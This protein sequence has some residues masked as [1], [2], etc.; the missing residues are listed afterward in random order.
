VAALFATPAAAT[1]N[2]SFGSGGAAEGAPLSYTSPA[3]AGIDELTVNFRLDDIVLTALSITDAAPGAFVSLRT[4]PGFTYEGSSTSWYEQLILGQIGGDGSFSIS[5][6]I[7]FGPSTQWGYAFALLRVG[8]MHG[9][10]GV[11]R[12][13][14]TLSAFA[15]EGYAAAPIP[16][17]GTWALMIVGL[18][19]MGS[20]LRRKR[21]AT[22]QPV[23]L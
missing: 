3:L 22:G 1:T 8:D 20:G 12:D 13:P 5:E 14:F 23:A 4:T 6:P 2:I 17:P 10:G 16:E 21:P 15:F 11:E 7:E 18:G 9:P 19:L